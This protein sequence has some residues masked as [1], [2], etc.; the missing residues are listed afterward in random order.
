MLY[1]Y[2]DDAHAALYIDKS[3]NGFVYIAAAPDP[4]RV[5]GCATYKITTQVSQ[6]RKNNAGFLTLFTA[7]LPQTGTAPENFIGA[8]LSEPHID[9]F[10]VN[11]LYIYTSGNRTPG[12]RSYSDYAD[13]FAFTYSYSSVVQSAR[14]LVP[15]NAHVT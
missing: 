9:G 5:Y 10:A 14:L 13:S 1:Q 7:L 11:F 3:C 12:S 8:S 4:A 15:I 2:P 6:S